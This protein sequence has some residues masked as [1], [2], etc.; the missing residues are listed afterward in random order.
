MNIPDRPD[1]IELEPFEIP[2][3]LTIIKEL[4]N[5]M[6]TELLIDQL[7]EPAGNGK[8]WAQTIFDRAFNDKPMGAYWAVIKCATEAGER[9][10]DE[11]VEM[12]INHE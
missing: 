2:D 6:A 8:S 12:R 7:F 5:K 10:E 9:A 11:W 4:P 1:P 3:G